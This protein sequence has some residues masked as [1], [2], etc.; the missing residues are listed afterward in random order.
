MSHYQGIKIILADMN[1]GFITVNDINPNDPAG[2]HSSDFEYEKMAFVW[3]AAFRQVET[4]GWLT[5]PPNTG[6]ADNATGAFTCPK[7]YGHG[8]GNYQI[9]KGSG[10]NLNDGPYVVT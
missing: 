7:L 10:T 6:T 4:N 5:T 8:D 2:E 3:W 1:D 9:Q